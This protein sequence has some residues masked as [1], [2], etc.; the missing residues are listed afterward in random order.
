MI[1]PE[2]A[3]ALIE[4]Y[5]KHGWELRR[6]L[7]TKAARTALGGSL[8]EIFGTAEIWPSENDALWFTRRSQ[9]GFES[10]E[11]RRLSS[12]PYALVDVI[13]DDSD[14]ET[15]EMRLRVIE[16]KMF[17]SGKRPEMSH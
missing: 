8:N 5:A 11:L 7:L 14:P 10:W 16:E 2:T 9:P 6:V 15:R 1:D 12:S 3:K 13:P 4:Q 17:E